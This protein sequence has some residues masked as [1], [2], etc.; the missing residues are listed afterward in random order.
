MVPHRPHLGCWLAG[1]LLALAA[2]CERPADSRAPPPP[3]TEPAELLASQRV[4]AWHAVQEL[5][6]PIA[7]FETVFWEP[8]D[9][10]SLREQI[11]HTPL[12]R[13][14]SV[15]EIGTG[16]GLVAL[17]C[18]GAGAS[19]VVATDINPAAVSNAR[20]NAQLLGWNS[21]L[22]VRLVPRSSPAAFSVVEDGERFDLIVSNPPW[23]PGTPAHIAEFALYDQ[24][25]ALLE[26]LLRGLPRYLQ[27]G[28]RALLAYGC[29][30][31]IRRAVE[32]AEQLQLRI[33]VLDDRRLEDL[34]EVFL[35]GMLLEVT[36]PDRETSG[37]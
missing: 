6:G 26:S 35:P 30:T 7:Q 20:Y 37:R 32:L 1:F 21:R 9:T 15:L 34:P 19:R 28:G 11:W 8:A 33:E 5:P 2:G 25:F 16:T 18:L 13:D 14:R 12:V 3:D 29:V 23:E 36:V 4:E 17:C 27:P 10:F 24:E 22:D 31:A